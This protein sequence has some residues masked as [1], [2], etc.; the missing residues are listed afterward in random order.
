MPSL[1]EPEVRRNGKYPSRQYSTHCFSSANS[2]LAALS[3][4]MKLTFWNQKKGEEAKS[5]IVLLGY[6]VAKLWVLD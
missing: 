5:R 1:H 3:K 2:N 4:A 6:A